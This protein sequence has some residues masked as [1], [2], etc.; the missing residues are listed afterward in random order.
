[1]ETILITIVEIIAKLGYFG[2]F[3]GMLI[4]SS[5]I[6]FPSEIIMIPAGYLAH[7][8][9]MNL[10]I[11]IIIGTLGSIAGALVNYYLAKFLGRTILTKYGKY[12]L[13]SE[14][15]IT[16]ADVFFQNHGEISTLTGRLLPV[17]RQ[18]ISIPAG[19]FKMNLF[20]FVVLTGIGSFAWVCVLTF[21]GFF[22][23]KNKEV[24]SAYMPMLKF[25]SI[26]VAILL[27][28]SYIFYKKYFKK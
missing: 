4:E 16:K 8:G 21:F 12:F 2:V 23:G 20:R 3:I 22:I 15:A 9:E 14:K 28:I 13:I 26:L 7:S 24:I 27:V 25:G 11:V 19:L 6:P 10:W 18:L 1:M 17:I 5:F